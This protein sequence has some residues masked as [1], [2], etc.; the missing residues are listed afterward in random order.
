M[1][2]LVYLTRLY[3]TRYHAADLQKNGLQIGWFRAKYS[4]RQ[5]QNR[6]FATVFFTRIATNRTRIFHKSWTNARRL[7]NQCPK[8]TEP[9]PEGSRSNARRLPNLCLKVP[10]PPGGVS[11][12]KEVR[13]AQKSFKSIKNLSNL[14]KIFQSVY[15]LLYLWDLVRFVWFLAQ[16]AA[17]RL[18]RRAKRV[19]L[20]YSPKGRLNFYFDTPSQSTYCFASTLNSPLT[21]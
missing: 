15:Q 3:I 19:E 13:F 6:Y 7:L 1:G 16:R 2:W 21:S 9:M 8:V 20:D 12:M 4:P 10:E 5:L 18:L 11:K 14:S 17:S